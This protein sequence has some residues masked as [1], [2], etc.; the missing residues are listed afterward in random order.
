[1]SQRVVV[2]PSAPCS[3]ECDVSLLQWFVTYVF[4][5]ILGLDSEDESTRILRNVGIGL[6]TNPQRDVQR[7]CGDDVTS[8]TMCKC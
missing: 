7:L 4:I 5:F 3:R 8:H 6:Y 2:D 1:M